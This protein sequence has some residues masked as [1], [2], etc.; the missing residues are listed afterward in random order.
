[1]KNIHEDE[2]QID[3]FELED[4]ESKERRTVSRSKAM[5]AV[6]GGLTVG[7][8]IGAVSG[9]Y[10]APSA[11]NDEVIDGELIV[12]AINGLVEILENAEAT[13][14]D[15]PAS[16]VGSGEE[17]VEVIEVD[18]QEGQVFN[19]FTAL[20][21]TNVNDNMSFAEAFATARDETGAGGVFTWNGQTYGTFYATEVNASGNPTIEYDV[22]SETQ[23]LSS[24]EASSEMGG[25]GHVFDTST[26][27]EATGVNDNMSF[28]EAFAAARDETGAGGVFTWNGQTY[29]TFYATE[30][31]TNF[32]PTIEYDTIDSDYIMEAEIVPEVE[33]LDGDND[34]AVI[35]DVEPLIDSTES[36][37]P[38]VPDHVVDNYLDDMDNLTDNFEDMGDWA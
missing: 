6:A 20:Q 2:T 7:L 24:N 1:M 23:S 13:P 21:S 18:I 11:E 38:D 37:I 33:I 16:D 17:L 4:S 14:P 26:A 32:N 25:S 3:E 27:P 29:S 36:G 5:L 12:G 15:S 8:G 28:A 10:A 31:D 9:A 30:V 35:T 34:L 19:P 22:L